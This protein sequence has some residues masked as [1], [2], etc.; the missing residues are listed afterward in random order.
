MNKFIKFCLIAATI[1]ISIGL[2]IGIA[3]T[4]IGGPSLIRGLSA[5]NSFISVPGLIGPNW[6]PWRLNWG[7][8]GPWGA[9]DINWN[10]LLV[11]GKKLDERSFTDSI[12]SDGIRRLEMETGV[13]EFMILP[14]DGDDFEIRVSGVGDVVYR[15]EGGTLFVAGF[16]WSNR[17]IGGS[18]TKNNKMTLY[19]PRY[20]V[21]DHIDIE[22]GVGAVEMRELS[23][24]A[25]TAE[26]G[27]GALEMKDMWAGRLDLDGGVGYVE[28][29][30]IIDGDV[31][32]NGSVGGIA[33]WVQGAEED[34]NYEMD[35][36]VGSVTVGS[37]TLAGLSGDR[38]INNNADK[39]MSLCSSVGAIEVKFY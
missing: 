5:A 20:M 35:T 13:G 21:F 32:V 38:Y 10:Y 8:N 14:H 22:V 12:N 2:C 28:Y 24:A 23:A 33:L 26:V 39:T 16:D 17:T 9:D 37:Y 27:V 19:V 18:S 1:M 7:W 4:A 11:N 15:V 30:G 34:F 29:R 36:S 3:V 31:E 25:I 6:G